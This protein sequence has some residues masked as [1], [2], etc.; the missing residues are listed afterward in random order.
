[1]ERAKV[2]DDAPDVLVRNV[3]IES[4]HHRRRQ[5]ALDD[6]ED[7]AI[8]R[9][10]VPLVVGEIRRLLASL[11]LDDGDRDA[12]FDALL[13]PGCRG[14]RRNWCR[15]DASPPRSIRAWRHGISAA[16]TDY[17]DVLSWAGA[18]QSRGWGLRHG[19]RS[20]DFPDHAVALGQE[21][22]LSV[23]VDRESQVHAAAARDHAPSPG[24]SVP[25]RRA[26]DTS[27][28]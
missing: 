28:R 9:S 19:S 4:R 17:G 3:S 14:R 12:G 5:S 22:E 16:A 7:V 11:L 27:L 1:M 21:V 23:V 26:C 8:A 15:R 20:D 2:V 25:S 6:A 10:V 18:E 13:A 24:A